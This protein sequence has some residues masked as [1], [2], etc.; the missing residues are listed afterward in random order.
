MQRR[1]PVPPG[2]SRRG[3]P[4]KI[5]ERLG[6]IRLA[7]AVPLDPK[8]AQQPPAAAPAGQA[9]SGQGPG[10]PASAPA[11]AAG[12]TVVDVTEA[13][14]ATEVV[15][16]SMQ[17]PVVV[18]FWASW[19]GPC[20]QLSPILEKLAA[21]DGGRW[22]LAKIDVDANPR[23]AQA[24]G[25]QG[26]PAVKAVLGGR[27][28]GEFT[29]ARPE[30][31]V[32][33]WL[34]QLLTLAAQAGLPGVAAAPPRD[35]NIVA[36]EEALARGDFDA[37]A[38]AYRARL[39][40]APADKEASLGLARAELLG[41]VRSYD[42]ADVQRRLAA[43]PDDVDAAIAAAELTIAGG[44]LAGGLNSLVDFVRDHS[45]DEREKARARLVE[46]FG[47]MGDGEPAVV[48]A[49]RALAAALF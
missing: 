3:G 14:F 21:A 18:D 33:A 39:A 49:R 36:A 13:T 37:A 11:G 32:R 10:Q 15:N 46:L 27:I 17:V 30:R 29:G 44:D 12:P 2:S 4:G 34:D 6:G 19:C 16:R 41:R 45:G 7:G 48:S 25:V 23:L 5:P 22:V 38:K 43:N 31:E 20:R 28:I 8:P 40:E 42:P 47:A 35:P 24:A 1:P 9:P 26:I